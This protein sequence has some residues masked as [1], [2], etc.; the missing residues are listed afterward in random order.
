[1]GNEIIE[2]VKETKILGIALDSQ[3]RFRAPIENAEKNVLTV[4]KECTRRE[5]LGHNRR[6]PHKL[7]LDQADSSPRGPQRRCQ[8]HEEAIPSAS[9]QAPSPLG[10]QGTAG[11]KS[12][13]LQLLW[14]PG[15]AVVQENEE[16][17][18]RGETKLQDQNK[19]HQLTPKMQMPLPRDIARNGAGYITL[20]C[21]QTACIA[22]P[23]RVGPSKTRGFGAAN[24]C[25]QL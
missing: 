20:R 9:A 1:M 16:Q 7:L 3:P 8:P 6:A 10:L 22:R 2:Q 5:R 14:V 23:L 13:N 24:L 11:S 12:T 17:N 25:A 18:T 21:P 15:H 19:P 4:W